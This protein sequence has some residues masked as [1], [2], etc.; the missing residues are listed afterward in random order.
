VPTYDGGYFSPESSPETTA[1]RF[2]PYTD[3]PVWRIPDDS[4]QQNEEPLL[5]DVVDDPDQERNLA[6][7]GHSAESRMRE[8]LVDAI[9]QLDAPDEQY[10]RLDLTD[11]R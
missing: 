2:V 1:G 4:V 3:L 11:V 10:Q 7:S 8:M 9:E 6:G 5:Y